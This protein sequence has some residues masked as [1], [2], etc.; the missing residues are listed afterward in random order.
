MAQPELVFGWSNQF[1][2]ILLWALAAAV[3][4]LQSEEAPLSERI[5]HAAYPEAV[6]SAEVSAHGAA[7]S[8]AKENAVDL[9]SL[10][11]SP[12]PLAVAQRDAASVAAAIEVCSETYPALAAVMA[13]PALTGHEERF[14]VDAHY[15]YG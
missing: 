3:A 10:I 9:A 6:D 15:R 13:Y 5:A 8:T 7:T 1:L 4:G 2:A 11:L 12:P 14:A